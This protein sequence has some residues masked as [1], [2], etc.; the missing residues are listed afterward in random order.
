MNK[1]KHIITL[2]IVI[3]F[4]AICKA[5]DVEQIVIDNIDSGLDSLK[6]ELKLQRYIF[7]KKYFY[8]G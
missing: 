6:Y 4:C 8:D 1:V 7:K 3:M 2:I 5:Q